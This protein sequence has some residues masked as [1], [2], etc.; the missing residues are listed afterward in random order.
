M[1]VRRFTYVYAPT[2]RRIH[3]VYHTTKKVVEGSRTA[4]GQYVH[5]MWKVGSARTLSR[6]KAC[7]KAN[8]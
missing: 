8:A 5:L 1:K 2:G 6:C 3:C 4:C 7:E